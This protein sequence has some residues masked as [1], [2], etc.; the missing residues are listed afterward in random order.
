VSVRYQRKSGFGAEP[1]Q[2]ECKKQEYIIQTTKEWSQQQV[3]T[4]LHRETNCNNMIMP[5]VCIVKA[6]CR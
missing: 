2:M 6:E 1:P 5:T 4:P 3:A